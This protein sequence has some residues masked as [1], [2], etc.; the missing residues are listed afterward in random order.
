MSLLRRAG[1]D[2]VGLLVAAII[3]LNVGVIPLLLSTIGLI[4]V[5]VALEY[6]ASQ[7]LR[8]AVIL[9][10]VGFFIGI[11]LLVSGGVLIGMYETPEL[12]AVGSKLLRAGYIV[13]A[14][15]LLLMG[16]FATFFWIG[17]DLDRSAR[18]CLWAVSVALPFQVVRII[19][20]LVGVFNSANS[21]WNT[22]EGSLG[23]YI[24]MV[25]VMEF[26]VVL[27]YIIAGLRIEP[28]GRTV[29]HQSVSRGLLFRTSK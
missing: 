17:R 27:T 19:Y 7:M 18:T 11:A 6:S 3:T 28:V 2:S 15:I 8:K 4:R 12:P 26:A 21:R 25:L 29:P 1:Q 23:L 13:L 14:F 16:V 20:A 10:R 24:G 5:I 22:L 9:I